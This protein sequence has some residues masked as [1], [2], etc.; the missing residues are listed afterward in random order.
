MDISE[1]FGETVKE[2]EVVEDTKVK[3]S[4]FDILDAMTIKKKDLNFNDDIVRKTY[5]QYMINRW[6][7]MGES[8]EL[9]Y[10]SEMLNTMT[11][12][13]DEQHFDLLKSVLPK[14]KYYFKY[15]KRTKDLTEKEKRYIA[16]YFEIGIREAE[17]YIRQMSQEEIDEI[18]KKYK[19]G[20]N[21]IIKI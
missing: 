3:F 15:L 13:T 1:F 11:N 17:D 14:Q 8:E 5:D 21:E 4:I 12:L 6:L 16:H 18:L 9:F 10:I 19:Y 20:K 2:E 7:S